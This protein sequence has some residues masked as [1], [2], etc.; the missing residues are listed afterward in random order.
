MPLFRF[1]TQTQR[2]FW[3]A[4]AEQQQQT[5]TLDQAKMDLTWLWQVR[6]IT[7]SKTPPNLKALSLI[8]AMTDYQWF[9]EDAQHFDISELIDNPKNIKAWGATEYR[10]RHMSE[11]VVLLM[12]VI[13]PHMNQFAVLEGMFEFVVYCFK[14]KSW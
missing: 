4:Y 9:E 13:Q 1:Y 7:H 11:M 2:Q 12:H 6:I 10:V 8:K 5:E 14:T 3:K